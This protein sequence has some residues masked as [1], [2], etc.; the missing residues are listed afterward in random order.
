MTEDK[1]A[2][3]SIRYRADNR[4][5]EQF[6]EDI[7]EGNRIEYEIIKRFCDKKGLE[8]VQ[9]GHDGGEFKEKSNSVAD[10]MVDGKPMEVKFCR[11]DIRRFHLKKYHVDDYIKQGALILFI[12][13]YDEKPMFCVID[14]NTVTHYPVRVFWQKLSYLCKAKDFTWEEL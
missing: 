3:S 2:K 4:S 6:K 9:L 11:K 14:P 5:I 1:K 13:N 12:M 8:F 10:F 7:L